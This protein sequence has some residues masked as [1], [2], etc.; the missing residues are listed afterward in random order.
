MIINSQLGGKKPSGTKQITTNGVHDVAGYASADVQVPTSAPAHYIEKSVDING[1]LQSTTNIINLTGVS[2]VGNNALS[3][4]YKAVA[5]PSNT[6]IDLSALTS[7]SGYQACL[8]MFSGC[9]GITSVDL[10][11]L[12]SI[13]G[14]MACERMFEGTGIT[15]VDLSALT[16]LSG[17]YACNGMF[18][19]CQGLTSID[20]SSLTTIGENSANDMFYGC[21]GI[22]SV[23]LSGLT[24]LSGG[25]AC[26]G[27]FY[28]CSSISTVTLSSLTYIANYGCY[29]MF[30]GMESLTSLY[31]PALTS[32]S[33]GGTDAFESMLQDNDGCT[34][35]FPSNLQSVIGSWQSVI[36]GFGGTNTTV[37]FD[38]P[39]TN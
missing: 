6:S 2:N 23:D 17:G 31:F 34:V 27:M 3:S 4:A 9:T 37:L 16:T 10:S 24:T 7:I 18:H 39:A 30:N 19:T 25:F 20:L 13:S 36:D 11:S 26:G 5:F 12:T 29:N 32:S 1:T 33:F 28:S 15:S 22:T 21:T 38:L 14:D 35:H 8:E